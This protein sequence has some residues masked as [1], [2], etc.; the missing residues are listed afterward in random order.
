MRLTRERVQR[1]RGLGPI[2]GRAELWTLCRGFVEPDPHEPPL[3]TA[4]G[5]VPAVRV[6]RPGQLEASL[7]P[8]DTESHERLLYRLRVA[9]AKIHARVG[10]D[11][12]LTLDYDPH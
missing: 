2:G 5:V 12:P 4:A 1:I 8:R 6:W 9:R 3:S 7:L 11:R 10:L